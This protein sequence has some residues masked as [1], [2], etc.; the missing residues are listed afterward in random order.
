MRK[1]DQPAE[2]EREAYM[3]IDQPAERGERSI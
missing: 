1:I 3:E 2:R